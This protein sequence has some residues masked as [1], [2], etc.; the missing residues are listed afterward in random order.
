MSGLL[1]VK[2]QPL[3]TFYRRRISRILPA[4]ISYVAVV[5]SGSLLSVH[6]VQLTDFL[7][8]LTFLRTYLPSNPG[9]WESPLPIGHLWSLNV[10]EHSYLLLSALVLTQWPKRVLG[11]SLITLGTLCIGIGF[12]YIKQ[13]DAV[14]KFSELQTEVAA[15]HLLISAGYRLFRDRTASWIAPWPPVLALAFGV[16]CYSDYSP[17]WASRLLGPFLLAFAVNHL[18]EAA[19]L[20]R[21]ILM[22][23]W[24]RQLGVWSFSIYLWQQPFYRFSETLPGGPLT[25]LTLAFATALISY[26]LIEKPSR[27]WLNS[28]WR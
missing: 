8:T 25:A 1:F 3:K 5:Y 14:S 10:E 17:W 9:I 22:Q 7:A 21:V 23:P 11:A 24:L 27:N 6:Q 15:S 26:Y 18:S 4:Y 12:L 20:L 19:S 13:P 2:W 28:N 16:A